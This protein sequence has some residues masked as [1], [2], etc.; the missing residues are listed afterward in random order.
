MNT[1]SK[2]S[3]LRYMKDWADE[4]A[5]ALHQCCAATVCR[6]GNSAWRAPGAARL[7]VLRIWSRFFFF[8]FFLNFFYIQVGRSPATA[9]LSSSRARRATERQEVCIPPGGPKVLHRPSHTLFLFFTHRQPPTNNSRKGSALC[10]DDAVSLLSVLIRRL[11]QL[12]VDPSG[13]GQGDKPSW[14]ALTFC[15]TSCP[16]ACESLSSYDQWLC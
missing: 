11:I 15:V 8:F 3:T 4:P 13:P 6:N 10:L 2:S 7:S 12:T 5:A 16:A 14:P 9:R 1:C